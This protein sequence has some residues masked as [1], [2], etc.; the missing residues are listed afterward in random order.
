MRVM[1][2]E[3]GAKVRSSDGQDVGKIKHL[4]VDPESGQVKTV[5]VEKGFLLPDD[6]SVP[7]D[8]LNVEKDGAIGLKY[9]ADEVQNLPRFNPAAY[10]EPPEGFLTPFP[11]PVGG[12]L[13]PVGTLGATP[14]TANG[15]AAAFMAEVGD[16]D[17]PRSREE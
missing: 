9:T 12:L 10:T 11:Y 14:T 3:L 13:W 8:A 17:M 16:E 7:I 6:V 15:G 5:V 1:R 2:T 4:I